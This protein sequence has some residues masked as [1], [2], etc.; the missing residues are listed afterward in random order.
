MDKR[1][2]LKLSLWT[3]GRFDE[4]VLVTLFWHNTLY[5]MINCKNYH[6][7]NWHLQPKFGV[8]IPPLH[9]VLFWVTKTKRASTAYAAQELI[10]LPNQ[11]LEPRAFLLFSLSCCEAE[12][13]VRR[14]RAEQ[15]KGEGNAC[16]DAHQSCS[17]YILQQP[18]Q[19]HKHTPQPEKLP[20][21][22]HNIYAGGPVRSS[23]HSDASRDT[24]PTMRGCLHVRMMLYEMDHTD[25]VHTHTHTHSSMC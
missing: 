9:W 22:R 18:P 10:N 14:S 25:K 3:P 6:E 11:H 8:C 21:L 17:L 20:S 7:N 2:K 4:Y 12:G 15:G 19:A 16:L 13:F 24:N 5:Y 23:V 1:G